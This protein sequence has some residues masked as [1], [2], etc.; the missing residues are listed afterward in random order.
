MAVARCA[1]RMIV[2]AIINLPSKI[3]RKD[4]IMVFALSNEDCLRGE[5]L[6]AF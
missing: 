6:S 2:D 4:F 1:K 3:E 5:V